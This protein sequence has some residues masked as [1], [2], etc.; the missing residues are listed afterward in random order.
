MNRRPLKISFNAF[1]ALDMGNEILVP[2]E[3][4]ISPG[5]SSS[6]LNQLRLALCS[7]EEL[8]EQLQTGNADALAILF[9]R[10][11]RL[12]FLICRRILRNDSE[13]E[14]ATQQVFLDVFRSIRQFD[15]KKGTF[16]TW[17]LMFAYHRTLNHRRALLA[18][19]FFDT[20][21]LDD[22]RPELCRPGRT[23]EG[24]EGRVLVQQVL[25]ALQPRQRRTIE[26]TYY[27]G[28]TAEEISEHTGETVRVVRHNLYRGIQ[29]LRKA[30]CGPT[31]RS[32]VNR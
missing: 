22:L 1:P 25:S 15:S 26:L 2:D 30:L 4:E 28:L 11:S 3:P 20:D 10:H 21:S 5:G 23:Y 31:V 19:R 18:A 8:A 6:L 24:P 29:Q 17:L 7:D 13:A 16:K 12:I 32:E 27:E 14:D 9:K